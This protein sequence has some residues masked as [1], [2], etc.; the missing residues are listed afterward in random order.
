[1]PLPIIY[2]IY[3]IIQVFFYL[4]ES[5]YYFLVLQ[6][7][8]GIHNYILIY[9][10]RGKKIML[11]IELVKLYN[12]E[13]RVLIQ[14]VKRNIESKKGV[15]SSRLTLKSTGMGAALEM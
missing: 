10:I 1:M 5:Q 9:L 11:S 13:G 12:V 6:G 3:R 2:F 4:I 8:F 14:A 7:L 15:R